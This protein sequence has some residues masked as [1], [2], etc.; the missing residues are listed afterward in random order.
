M[1]QVEDLKY[2]VKELFESKNILKQV[3]YAQMNPADNVLDQIFDI[4]QEIYELV[5]SFSSYSNHDI[6]EVLDKHLKQYSQK[7]F[8]PVTAGLFVNALINRL[9]LVQDEINLDFNEL[10]L[11]VIETAQTVADAQGESENKNEIGFSLDYIGYLL[12]DNKYLKIV[13]PVGD[14]CGALMG[15]GS[16]LELEGMHGKNFGYEKSPSA[17]IYFTESA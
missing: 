16:I 17:E 7:P 2:A 5:N 4:Y 11:E 13:G 1:M 14:Y 9:F 8:F 3:V 6:Q 10:C 15:N 12:P